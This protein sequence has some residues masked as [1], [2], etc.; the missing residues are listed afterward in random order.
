MHNQSNR[1]RWPVLLPVS[2]GHVIHRTVIH[3]SVRSDQRLFTRAF[4]NRSNR[5]LPTP[6]E[7]AHLANHKSCPCSVERRFRSLIGQISVFTGKAAGIP[8]RYG[9]VIPMQTMRANQHA[10]PHTALEAAAFLKRN[11]ALFAALCAA[12][13]GDGGRTALQ[14]CNIRV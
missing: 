13:N 10:C 5:N 1:R 6:P 8:G 14:L 4:S 7:H 2:R 12:I 3:T 11:A 9:Q